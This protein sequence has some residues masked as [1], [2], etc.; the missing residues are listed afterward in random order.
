LLAAIQD[1]RL[2]RPQTH[3]F[4]DQIDELEKL[5]VQS[6]KAK[7]KKEKKETKTA[8]KK[9]AIQA[10]EKKGQDHEKKGQDHEKEQ[11]GGK[12]GQAFQGDKSE[13]KSEK[14]SEELEAVTEGKNKSKPS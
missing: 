8:E 10:H 1:C 4:P 6:T 3:L 2:Y 11:I 9:I 14:Q 13:N 5:W 12:Q 7:E